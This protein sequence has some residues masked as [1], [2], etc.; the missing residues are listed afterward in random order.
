LGS[1]GFGLAFF[2]GF[3]FLS[4]VFGVEAFATVG[5]DGLGEGGDFGRIDGLIQVARDEA[6]AFFL[7]T[8]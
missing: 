4:E 7:G 1:I 3:L 8:V 6:Q 5:R 2:D